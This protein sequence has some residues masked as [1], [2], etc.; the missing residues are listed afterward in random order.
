MTK[1]HMTGW[2]FFIGSIILSVATP[3]AY[4][5]DRYSDIVTTQ[6]GA[7]TAA[8][9]IAVVFAIRYIMFKMKMVAQDGFRMT[10][11]FARELR[12]FFPIAIFL[13]VV[14]AIENNIA[15]ITDI[16][17]VTL[18]MNLLAAPLRLLSYR[19]S[20]RY[21]NDTGTQKLFRTLI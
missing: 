13:L 12:Y 15:G 21:E 18:L 14:T 8:S 1:K 6:V 5:L 17:R 3:I 2:A 4:A 16:V 20:K 9:I 11:E 7:I 10:K 19:L